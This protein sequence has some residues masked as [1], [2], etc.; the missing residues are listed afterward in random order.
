MDNRYLDLMEKA[1]S[2]YTE[3]DLLAYHKRVCAEG[4]TEHGYPR[5]AS[6]IGILLAHGR[7]R[8]LLPLFLQMF[9]LCC[10]DIAHH[11]R[12]EH[13][14]G[15]D[16]AVLEMIGALLEVERAH[17]FPKETTD[18][19]RALLSSIDPRR[20]YDK[21]DDHSGKD[22][23]NWI[24]FNAASEQARAFAGLTDPEEFLASQLPGQMRAINRDGMYLDP[25]AHPIVYDLVPRAILVMLLHYGYAGALREEIEDALDRSADLTLYMQSAVGEIPYGGRSN[26]MIFNEAVYDI[27]CEYYARRFAARGDL[28]RAGR[29]RRAGAFATER[30]FET[31][32][33][34]EQKQVKNRFPRESMF[35]CEKYAYFDKYMITV[36]SYVY[37]ARLVTDDGIAPTDC[38]AESEPFLRKLDPTDFHRVFL[39]LSDYSMQIDTAADAHY[40]ASG[41][42]RIH[43]KGVPTPIALTVPFAKHPNYSL[44]TDG[45]PYENPSPFSIAPA[46]KA[47]DGTLHSGAGSKSVYEEVA[48]EVSEHRVAVT[49]RVKLHTG[50][51]IF[52]TAALDEDGACFTA[53]GDGDVGIT[54]PLFAFDGKESVESERTKTAAA[55]F[56]SGFV[57]RYETDGEVL[58]VADD[59]R[60]RSGIYRGLLAVGKNR[61]SLRVRIGKAGE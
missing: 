17:L 41:V 1:L 50:E 56:Y 24:L 38:P 30:L 7:R 19:W 31:L 23:G 53:E 8:E 9:S 6:N 51:E 54:F 12:S 11:D 25:P 27:L 55:V 18:G 26:Q 60:N 58:P 13:G 5:L 36:A 20:C 45:T 57:C 39:H 46:Q 3:D 37:M 28:A 16:F 40:D 22:F 52:F 49:Y 10:T 59:F 32:F 47:A 42:G 34:K 48:E 2:N 35:G 21:I 44:S 29:F 15:N 33:A 61:V 4:I 14:T 43:R